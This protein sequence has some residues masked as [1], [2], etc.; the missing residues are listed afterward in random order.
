[1][2]NAS[3]VRVSVATSIFSRSAVWSSDRKLLSRMRLRGR[4][5]LLMFAPEGLAIVTVH[6]IGIVLEELAHTDGS[7]G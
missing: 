7:K 6:G 2:N 1:M 4:I 5:G 3:A